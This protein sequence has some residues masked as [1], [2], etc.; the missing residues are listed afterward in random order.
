MATR[1][2]SFNAEGFLASVK[3]EKCKKK[4]KGALVQLERVMKK[5]VIT[6]EMFA[7]RTHLLKKIGNCSQVICG[8]I[9]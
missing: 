7:C 4:L 8:K 9:K 1:K 6:E 5:E 3:G 2:V